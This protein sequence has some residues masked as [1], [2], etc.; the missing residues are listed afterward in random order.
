MNGG[1]VMLLG[2]AVILLGIA[3][4]TMNFLAWCAGG[5]GLLIVIAGFFVKD[6]H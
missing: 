4:G 5:T 6:K 1:K 2:I 3:I